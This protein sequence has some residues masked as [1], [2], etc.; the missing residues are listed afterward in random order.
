LEII[1]DEDAIQRFD[2]QLKNAELILQKEITKGFKAYPSVAACYDCP[3]K[4]NCAHYTDT[5]LL[6]KIYV[7]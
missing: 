6:Q 7:S 2:G 3:I 4:D 1:V 5:P